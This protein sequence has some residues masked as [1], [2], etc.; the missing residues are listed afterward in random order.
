VTTFVAGELAARIAA[1]YAYELPPFDPKTNPGKCEI[2][3]K[4]AAERCPDGN[5]RACHKSLTMEACCD[6]SWEREARGG[7]S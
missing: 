7:V 5:C 3:K 2:C 6:G 1:M 4:Q